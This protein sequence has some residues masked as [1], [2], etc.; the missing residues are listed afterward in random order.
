MITV[1]FTEFRNRASALLDDVERGEIV[2]ILRHGKPVAEVSPLSS[3]RPE[4]P[5]WK[6][7]GIKLSAKGIG[8][9]RAIV[10][11]RKPSKS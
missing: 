11:E 8:L 6:R 5:S 7:P 2:R 3:E 4:R 10:D 1:S 9:S